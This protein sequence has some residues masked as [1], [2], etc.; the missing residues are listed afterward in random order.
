MQSEVRPG[1]NPS[2]PQPRLAILKIRNFRYYWGAT[3]T[4]LIGEHIE[5]VI[6]SWVVWEITGSVFW[7]SALIFIHWVPFHPL[8]PACG[9]DR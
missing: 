6:R 8:Q 7:L 5:G 4:S 3:I 2:A 9:H 1:S